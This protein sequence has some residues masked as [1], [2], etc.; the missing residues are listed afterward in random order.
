MMG[1]FMT[2]PGLLSVSLPVLMGLAVLL[3]TFARA[4]DT[5][6]P[7]AL[8]GGD[9]ERGRIVFQKVGYCVNC[10]GWAGD[11]QSGRNPLSHTAA[12]NLRETELDTELLTEVIKCGLP[13]TKMPYH[14]S[15]AYRDD[16]CYGM[17]ISD[18]DPG[19]EPIRGKTFRDK[20]V[21]NLVAYLQ[22]HVIGRGKP[23]FEE[24]ADYYGASTD[25]ACAYLK[26]N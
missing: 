21:A 26:T 13:G 25:K 14:D 9:P 10:H 24:C 11:G 18:F 17:V 20:D 8:V 5:A 3:S 1:N 16:R 12:A 22:A 4:Q 6:A 23:T 7:M 2:L 19:S 15:A